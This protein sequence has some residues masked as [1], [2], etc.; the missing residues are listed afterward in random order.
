MSEAFLPG[1]KSIAHRFLIFSTLAE[2][3]SILSGVP[4]S[5]DVASTMSCLRALGATFEDSGDGMIRVPGPVSWKAASRALDCGNSGTTARLLTGLLAGLGVEAE[6]RG[7]G[8]LSERPMDRVVYP[9]QAMGARIT[10]VG[11]PDRLPVRVEGR[12]TGGLRSLRYRPRVSS[13]QVRAALL[14]AALTG[15]TD[16]EIVDRFRPRDHTERILRSMG[17]PVV[18]EPAGS[19]ERIRLPAGSWGGGLSPLHAT[20]PGDI[21]A[22]CFLFA[23][24]LLAGRPLTL[25]AVG[26]NPTRTGFLRVVEAMGAG[27]EVRETGAQAGEPV[28]DVSLRP[29][30]LRPFAL[31]EDAVPQLIDE[32]PA[33]AVLAC[34]VEG[35][36]VIRGAGELRVKESDRLALLASNLGEMGIRCDES[37]DGL[38]V[39][40][41]RSPLEGLARTGG[42]HRI[43]MAFGALGSSP[44][45]DVTVDDPDCVDVSFPGFWDA[46]NAVTTGLVS[47]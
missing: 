1:D 7:D 33:L 38:Q 45:C 37:E 6:L 16:L 47:P 22:A 35:V 39:H 11:R 40:G 25:R 12:A 20:V 30:R 5:L 23:A 21:S 19:G 4:S 31:Q 24:A 2:G 32:I 13:A 17:A 36:S 8:S 26:L 15:H 18:S 29:A 43:A 3:E 44:G 9:L 41:S 14:L 10:Y 42:D 28:G 27:V 46:L 34:R